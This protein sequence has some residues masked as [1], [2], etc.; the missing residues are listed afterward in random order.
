MRLLGLHGRYASFGRMFLRP[1]VVNRRSRGAT[2]SWVGTLC[3]TKDG[4]MWNL[5][6]GR[7]YWRIAIVVMRDSLV[8]VV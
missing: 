6:M 8:E 7:A 2:S 4:S 1:M 3:T 5:V